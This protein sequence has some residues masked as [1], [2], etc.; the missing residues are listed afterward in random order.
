MKKI[1]KSVAA[2]ILYQN[3]VL[4]VKRQNELNS[5]PGYSAFPGGKVKE[6]EPLIEAVKRELVEELG[7]DVLNSIDSIKE[8]GTVTTPEFNPVRFENTYF[9]VKLNRK[10]KIKLETREL[11]EAI[12]AEAQKFISEY[13]EGERLFVKPMVPILES[14]NEE[15][16]NYK[17][18]FSSIPEIQ[19]IH[20]VRQIMPLSNTLP[21]AN[22]TNCFFI[23]DVLI[24]PSPKDEAVMSDLLS[25][26]ENDK[27]REIF[28]THHHGDHRQFANIMAKQLKVPMGMSQDTFDRIS[29]KDKD[30]FS[31]VEVKIFKEGMELTKW[32]GEAVCIY[33]TPGHDEG[34]LGLA[35]SSMKWFIAGDLFQGVGSVVVGGDEGDMQKYFA[36]LKKVIALKPQCVYPSHGIALGGTHIIEKNLKHR[37]IR[38]EQIIELL[39]LGRTKDE[40]LN[41]I[42]IGL[43]EKL[44]PYAMANIDSHLIKIEK[45]KLAL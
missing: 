40:I 38:E 13:F 5:F 42:Y 14:L 2:I 6:N 11:A 27:V 36:S 7:E 20:E 30:Y 31:G 16:L 8:W 35:P 45:E 21:P 44:K 1:R 15:S 24:D 39:S 22:R 9:K 19:T 18:N 23:G 3:E 34:H 29:R 43:P 37:E 25:H 17:H 10:P 26:I 4:L 28:L 41:T 32:K 33:E 12:W